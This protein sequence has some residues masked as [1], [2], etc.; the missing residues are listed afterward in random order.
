MAI[1]D[2]LNDSAETGVK[3]TV[4]EARQSFI[5]G[6]RLEIF[7]DGFVNIIEFEALLFKCCA[8]GV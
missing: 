1:V 6:D 2:S 4:A 5:V 3:T 7:G 8:E